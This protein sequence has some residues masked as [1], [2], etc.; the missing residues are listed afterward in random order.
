MSLVSSNLFAIPILHSGLSTFELIALSDI[1]VVTTVLTENGPQL[2]VQLLFYNS[3]AT[4]TRNRLLTLSTSTL[5]VIA[6]ILNYCINKDKAGEAQ[7]VY[8]YFQLKKKCNKLR[9]NIRPKLA[10]KFIH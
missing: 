1:R 2:L 8:H 5:S 10:R 9:R 3:V 6:S 7:D 4:F